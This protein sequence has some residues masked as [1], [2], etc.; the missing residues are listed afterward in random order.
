[1]RTSVTVLPRRAAVAAIAVL[2]ALIW[3]LGAAH[4]SSAQAAS[5]DGAITGV[6]IK[7]STAGQFTSMELDLTWAVPD[8]ANG[9]DTFTLKLPPDLVSR[10][11]S[12]ELKAPDGSIVANAVVVNGV[13][14]FT[15]TD[16]ANTHNDVHGTAFFFVRWDQQ[17]LPTQGPVNLDFT[18]TTTVYHDTVTY[19]G[20]GTPGAGVPTKPVKT[21]HWI[22]SSDPADNAGQ[23]ALGW[24]V[25]SP[26]GPFDQVKV[27]DSVGA[28][29][30]IDC[31][32]VHYQL[33]TLDSTGHETSVKTLPAKDVIAQS[34]STDAVSATLGPALAG[35]LIRVAYSSSITDPNLTTYTNAA[36]VSVDGHSLGSVS[37]GVR[38]EGSGGDGNGN[39]PT[40]SPSTSPSTSPTTS[41]SVSPTSTSTTST[42]SPTS[43]STSP[44]VSPTSTSTSPNTS[45]TVLPTK[46]T[47]SAS[48]TSTNRGAVLAFTGSNVTPMLTLAGLLLGG[49][50]LMALVGR[51]RRKD[52]RH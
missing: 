4:G 52:R 3:V 8:S 36:D 22:G 2:V 34:C 49:G 48:A 13:V 46:L 43:T 21:G 40:T 20:S 45:P 39:S 38:R 44:S 51:P 18:T 24:V 32:T 28:G 23:D 47:N 9:G 41:P 10:T 17:N 15:L 27:S 31:S 37:T 30:A 42:T 14:T 50:A 35:Q 7:Q 1:V 26:G 12:F 19:T 11:T 16:Y 29:Q 25:A 33:V 6:N 5:I